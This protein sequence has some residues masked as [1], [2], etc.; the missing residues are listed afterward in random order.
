VDAILAPLRAFL[1]GPDEQQQQPPEQ[2]QKP[3][4]ALL[5][6]PM[7]WAIAFSVIADV[8]ARSVVST[9]P[10]TVRRG[11]GG[12]KVGKNSTSKGAIGLP[13]RVICPIIADR[14]EECES[15]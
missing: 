8:T 10:P 13:W 6:A 9:S 2:S 12:G 5:G 4:G 3:L 14:K 7:R 11:G 1:F 15:C